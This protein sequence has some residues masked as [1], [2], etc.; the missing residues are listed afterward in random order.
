MTQVKDFKLLISE[1][2]IKKCVRRLANLIAN[3]YRGKDLCIVSIMCGAY[4]FTADLLR[5]LSDIGVNSKLGFIHVKTYSGLLSVV[6][7][8]KPINLI[9]FD[10]RGKDLLVI[11]DIIDTG[12]TI[13]FLAKYILPNHP[14]SLEICSFLK[15]KVD[16]CNI[17]G[18]IKVKYIGFYIPDKFVVGYGMDYNEKYRNLKSIQEIILK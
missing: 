9:P 15:K 4:I 3:D 18:L 14:K 16:N 2:K 12:N 11:E 10:V 8:I 13:T 7:K 6:K 1:K 17:D 5:E